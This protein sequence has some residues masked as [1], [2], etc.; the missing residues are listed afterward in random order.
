M[1]L[2]VISKKELAGRLRHP[3]VSTVLE[4]LALL[5]EGQAVHYEMESSVAARKLSLAL[6]YYADK[7]KSLGQSYIHGLKVARRNKSVFCWLEEE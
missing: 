4:A 6:R 5:T 2:T 7:S 1:T 3:E